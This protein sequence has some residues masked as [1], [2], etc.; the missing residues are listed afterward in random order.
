MSQYMF[1]EV[2]K[3]RR[4]AIV[5]RL[6]GATSR[7]TA[8]AIHDDEELAFAVAWL[9]HHFIYKRSKGHDEANRDAAVSAANALMEVSRNVEEKFLMTREQ[10]KINVISELD[11]GVIRNPY[12][13][14]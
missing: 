8:A 6:D 7:V 9:V 1:E 10:V 2:S 3:L 14:L 5:G 12:A 4:N 11:K 13:Y